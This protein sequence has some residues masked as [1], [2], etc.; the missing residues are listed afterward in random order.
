MEPE[1]R[2]QQPNDGAGPS[3]QQQRQQPGPAAR[4]GAEAAAAAAA[5]GL[6]KPGPD[7]GIEMHAAYFTT[8]LQRA[9]CVGTPEGRQV[10]RRCLGRCC[11]RLL[12]LRC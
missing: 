4:V 6:A 1:Q 7:A 12:H 3:Q 8:L 9:A 10:S 11:T 5:A 2:D